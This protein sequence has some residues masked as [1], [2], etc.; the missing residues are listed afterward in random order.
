MVDLTFLERRRD[1]VIFLLLTLAI[2]LLLLYMVWPWRFALLLALWAGYVLWWPTSWLT[3]YIHRRGIAAL[4][5]VVVVLVLLIFSLLNLTVILVKELAQMAAGAAASNATIS[6]G[7]TNTFKLVNP[8]IA[9]AG[10]IAALVAGLATGG[11]VIVTT[12]TQTAS[13]IVRNIF[14]N[15]P[16]LLFQLILV[17]VIL[18]GLLAKGDVIVNDFKGITPPKYRSL[19][20]RFLD[21]LNPIYYTFFVI[22]AI[23]AVLCG[24]IAAVIYGLLGV[25]Y[26][27]TFAIFIVFV[28]LIPSIGR[29]LIYIPLAIMLLLQ[30]Q[31]VQGLLV[32]ILSIVI[33]EA[34]I[35]YTIQPRWM[36][37]TAK[38]PRVLTLIAFTFA[39]ASFGIVGFA[40]G[41]ALVGFALA[42]WR[43]YKDIIKEQ[44]EQMPSTEQ[45]ATS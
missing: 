28:G 22:Y 26:F 37:R 9:N 6:G 25:P 29:A 12:F 23:V 21:H 32:L 35:R 10:P 42:M 4:I 45:A 16:L 36:E 39:L 19:V 31:T 43:T 14:I 44:E 18:I 41:P 27:I 24:I 40:V 11:S 5:V 7:L 33:F 1:S 17:F 15:I 20:N 13:G 2:V 8:E 38:I 3:K 34:I 30:G